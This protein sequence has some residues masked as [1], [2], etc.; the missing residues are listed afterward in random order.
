VVA[1]RSGAPGLAATDLRDALERHLPDRTVRLA[2]TPDEEREL[3]A[4]AAVVV[5]NSFTADLLERAEGLELYAHASSGVDSLPLAAFAERGVAVTNAAGLMPSI[6]EQV[7][8]YL[9][10]FARDLRE[11]LRR[12]RRREWRHYQPGELTGSTVTV[13]G[14]GAIGTQ[15]LTRLEPF[16]VRRIGVRHTPSKGGPADEI[17]GYDGLHEALRAT[18]YLVLSC[19]LTDLTRGIVGTEELTTLP[20]DAVV[21]NVARGEVVQTDALVTA[22]RRNLLGG[23]ALDVTDPEPLPEDHALWGLDNVVVTPHNAGSSANHWD[24]VA[25]LLAENLERAD[26]SGE[27]TG[28]ENQVVS[29]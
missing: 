16:G 2:Q 19:P 6:S 28:L 10:T 5:S 25:A 18:D 21:V 7:L 9:L 13:V 4:E 20:N 17:L 12:Q 24:R 1:L 11:G 14:L 29:P 22:L 8:G 23:A 26:E 3:V 27:Y 15:I